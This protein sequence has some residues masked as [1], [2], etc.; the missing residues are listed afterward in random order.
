MALFA[1][2]NRLAYYRPAGIVRYTRNLIQALQEVNN[3]D[4]FIEWRHHR[5]ARVRHESPNWKSRALIS[6]V[7]HRWEQRMLQFEMLRFRPA[8]AHF[9]D[10]VSPYLSKQKSVITVH[11]LAFLHWPQLVTKDAKAYYD[12]L[13]LA[14][15]HAAAVITPSQFTCVDLMENVPQAKGKAHVIHSGLAPEF[16]QENNVGNEGRKARFDLPSEFLLHVGTLEPR[17]NI[18]VLLKAFKM[19]RQN[20]SHSNLFLVLAGAKGWRDEGIYELVR[21]LDIEEFCFFPGYLNDATLRQTYS[22]ALCLVHPALYE[23][24]G[25]TLLESMACETPVV[26]SNAACLTEISGNAAIYANPEDEEE[27]AA[28]ILELLQDASLR[29]DLIEKGRDRA[30][31]FKWEKTAAATLAIYH[32][33]MV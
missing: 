1:I 11:D 21:E 3:S 2:D 29:Q 19:V 9:P 12:Q 13:P 25:F 18:P 14:V 20:K 15:E 4:S 5:Q 26:C 16:L 32:S 27:F 7:H 23:G 22:Q 28:R 6:P 33:V 24:F 30:A 17:K 31:A 10:Y 8:V